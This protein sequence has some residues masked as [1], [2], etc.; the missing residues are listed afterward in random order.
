MHVSMRQELLKFTL[1]LRRSVKW[2]IS[3]HEQSNKKEIGMSLD[4]P[5]NTLGIFQSDICDQCGSNNLI[6]IS[7]KLFFF[8]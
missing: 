1:R 7:L 3:A 6:E 4:T 8:C 2:D 5:R